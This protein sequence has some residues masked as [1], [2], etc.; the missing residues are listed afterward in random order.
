ML[1]LADRVF[2]GT[3]VE[4]RHRPGPG[5]LPVRVTRFLVTEAVEGDYGKRPEVALSQVWIGSNRRSGVRPLPA[6]GFEAGE[7]VLVF[8]HPD[9]SLGLSSPVGSGLGKLSVERIEGR[10]VVRFSPEQ[11][12]LLFRGLQ[13]G[14][15]APPGMGAAEGVS[16]T[17]PLESFLAWLRRQVER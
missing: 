15:G 2:V 6:P 5:D 13:E 4:V 11:R 17:V 16:E 3:V 7:E 10:R 1:R 8:L 9:S 14:P 12:A